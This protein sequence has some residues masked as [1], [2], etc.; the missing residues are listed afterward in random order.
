M[1]SGKF[2]FT[3]GNMHWKFAVLIKAVTVVTVCIE[4]ASGE[5]IHLDNYR[6]SGSCN[7]HYFIHLLCF[8]F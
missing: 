7:G 1:L 6:P 3:T 5:H 2:P 8:N 4:Y